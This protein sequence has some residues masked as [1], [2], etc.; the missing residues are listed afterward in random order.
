MTHLYVAHPIDQSANRWQYQLSELKQDVRNMLGPGML[1]PTGQNAFWPGNAWTLEGD[2]NHD[3]IRAVNEVAQDL[4]WGTLALLPEGVPTLGVPV[5]IERS[6]RAGKPTAI[7]ASAGAMRGGVQL[8]DWAQ[9]G[10]CVTDNVRAALSHLLR[11]PRHGKRNGEGKTTLRVVRDGPQGQLPTQG[12]PGDAGFDLYVSQAVTIPVGCW[13]NVPCDVRVEFP[14]GVWGLI[15]G[16]S[17]TFMERHL[18]VNQAVIDTGYRG[19]LYAAVFNAG[20]E[21]AKIDAGDR[22]AQVIPMP[23]LA[24]NCVLEEVAE[25]SE[26]SRGVQGFGSSGR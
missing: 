18:I 26:S 14:P 22:L 23:N 3:S 2:T 6:I 9:R 19:P 11:A 7:V 10:A 5:E 13:V 4:A 20:D 1:G 21:K 17:S 12:Y 16:R 24:D 8:H 25:L 15:V